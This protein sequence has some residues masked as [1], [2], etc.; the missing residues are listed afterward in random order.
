MKMETALRALGALAHETRL[1]AFR[2]LVQASAPVAASDLAAELQVAPQTLS[3]HLKELRLAGLVQAD[4]QGRSIFYS[5][6]FDTLS[7]LSA[8]LLEDCCGGT[9]R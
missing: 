6:G 7:A 8:F 3:F 5:P 1:K 2:A 9:G 4:R